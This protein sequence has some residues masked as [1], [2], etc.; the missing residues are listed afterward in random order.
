MPMMEGT[1]RCGWITRGTRSQVISNVQA[2]CRTEHQ[3]AITPA[4]FRAIWRTV[5]GDAAKK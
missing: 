4:E 5:E 1:F 3:Q 2:H